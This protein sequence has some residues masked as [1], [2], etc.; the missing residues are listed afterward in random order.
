MSALL[1]PLHAQPSELRLADNAREDE[2]PREAKAKK[3]V[4]LADVMYKPNL[5]RNVMK[6]VLA[7][8]KS[9]V[10]SR[11]PL[12]LF[13]F[14]MCLTLSLYFSSSL[15]TSLFLSFFLSLSICR[16]TPYLL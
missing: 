7:H 2:V 15:S 9:K 13:S 10:S 5:N 4:T 12:I 14:L 11:K 3:Y 1:P 16:Q 8:N 6:E